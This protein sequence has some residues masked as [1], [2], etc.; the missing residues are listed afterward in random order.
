MATQLYMNTLVS[1]YEC[2]AELPQT[3]SIYTAYTPLSAV[4]EIYIDVLKDMGDIR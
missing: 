2:P 3:H 4:T 1:M